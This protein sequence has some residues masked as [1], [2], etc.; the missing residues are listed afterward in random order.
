MIFLHSLKNIFNDLLDGVFGS[1][2]ENNVFISSSNNT[3]TVTSYDR[4]EFSVVISNDDNNNIVSSMSRLNLPNQ[5]IAT[6]SDESE[7]GQEC[8]LHLIFLCAYNCR[9]N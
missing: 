6:S 4:F 2:D 7:A 9:I 3:T 5:Q 1:D 8:N